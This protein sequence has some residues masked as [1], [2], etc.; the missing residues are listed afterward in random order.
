VI[1]VWFSEKEH[2]AVDRWYT[3]WEIKIYGRN[4][5]WGPL[6]KPFCCVSFSCPAFYCRGKII[7][8]MPASRKL[9]DPI[10]G[11]RWCWLI[12]CSTESQEQERESRKKWLLNWHRHNRAMWDQNLEAA[13]IMLWHINLFVARPKRVSLPRVIVSHDRQVFRV[14][15]LIFARSSITK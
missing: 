5:D 9:K 6:T 3:K 15:F 8:A 12:L 14:P 1:K 13:S 11:P 10:H 4:F 2:K 7:K